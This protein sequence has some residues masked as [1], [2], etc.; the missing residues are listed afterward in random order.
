M[1]LKMQTQERRYDELR[2][3]YDQALQREHLIKISFLSALTVLAPRSDSLLHACRSFPVGLDIL[4]M[5]ARARTLLLAK[6]TVPQAVVDAL[7]TCIRSSHDNPFPEPSARSFLCDRPCSFSSSCGC[8]RGQA[9][10]GR[11]RRSARSK[12]AFVGPRGGRRPGEMTRS[13]GIENDVPYL[14]ER[15]NT[16]AATEETFTWFQGICDLILPTHPDLRV[17]TACAG[18]MKKTPVYHKHLKSRRLRANLSRALRLA[19][20]AKAVRLAA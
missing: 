14:A 9:E 3:Q 1:V 4:I 7:S 5:V 19:R 17:L 8:V 11:R 12:F 20:R 15:Q 10:E 13:I 18:C 6:E 2:A 16:V